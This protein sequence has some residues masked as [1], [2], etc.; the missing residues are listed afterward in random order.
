MKEIEG[1]INILFTPKGI[2][3]EEFFELRI[4][5]TKSKEVGLEILKQAFE[6]PDNLK[7][8]IVVKDKFKLA[9][10]IQEIENNKP[11]F[12]MNEKGSE[13]N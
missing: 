12:Q 1:S 10:K 11:K 5:L 7:I 8:K 3:K 6:N 13:Q 2:L 4:Y 9:S